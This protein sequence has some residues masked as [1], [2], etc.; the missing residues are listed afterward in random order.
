M[1]PLD[2]KR[3][4]RKRIVYHGFMGSSHYTFIPRE[5]LN[6]CGEKSFQP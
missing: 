3:I 1:H 5:I 4:E 6:H 2:K